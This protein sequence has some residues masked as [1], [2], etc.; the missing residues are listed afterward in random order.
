MTRYYKLNRLATIVATGFILA[1]CGKQAD[2]EES[3]QGGEAGKALSGEVRIAGSSTVYPISM[4]MAEEFFKKHSD[5]RIPVSST[6]TGGGFSNF[7]IPGKTDIND[8][9]RKIKES[10]LKKCRANDIEPV[11]FQIAIDAVTIVA[12]KNADW[13]DCMTVNELAQIWGPKNPPQ[14]WNEVRPEWPDKEFELYGAASTS[15]TFDYFTENIIGKADAHR[16][17]YQA[18]EHDNTIVQGVKGSKY[19]LGYF[20]FAYYEQNKDDLKAIA[21]DSGQGCVKPTKKNAQE[22]NYQPLSRPL[23]IYVSKESL[24]RPVVRE[25]IEFYMRQS[26]SQ[27]MSQVGYVPVPDEVIEQ[28][29]QKLR[30]MSE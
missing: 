10:E 21:V 17:D 29:L 14:K 6:G 24:K 26:G 4:A 3:G 18:T 1:G 15:G 7:F 16:S 22:G 23:F 12:N 11:E 9:S 19:A 8:A 5:V 27:L 20:G 13:V 30:R 28:N 25:F 2:N